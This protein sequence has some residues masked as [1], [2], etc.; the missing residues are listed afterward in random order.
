[1]QQRKGFF[2]VIDGPDGT[3]K[4]VAARA[5]LK[6]LRETTQPHKTVLDLDAYWQRYHHH[7]QFEEKYSERGDYRFDYLDPE[8]F[9]IILASEPT[10][11]EIGHAIRNEIVHHK[12]KYNARFTAE[13][14]AADRLILYKRVLLPALERGKIWIQQRSFSTSIVYQQAQAEEL[15]EQLTLPTILSFQG[16]QLAQQHPPDLL[17]IPIIKDVERILARNKQRAKDDRSF[18]ESVAFQKHVADTY[19]SQW[20]KE[21][22]ENIGTIVEYVDG[23]L[24][25]EEYQQAIVE[26][27]KKHY[28]R[29]K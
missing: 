12:G 9:D 13:M 6:Y 3:G 18:F 7:P 17:I 28:P 4:E 24:P 10:H 25:M 16:N 22:F 27:V 19:A 5:A 26:I 20:L 11:T 21:F 29:I 8:H 14:F 15:S 2:I 1:M 23:E